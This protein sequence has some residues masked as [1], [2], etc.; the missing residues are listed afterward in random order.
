MRTLNVILLI[1][2][3][4]FFS[5]LFFINDNTLKIVF[6]I[7]SASLPTIVAII[8]IFRSRNSDI[9]IK[10]ELEKR[11]K[12]VSLTK[13]EYDELMEKNKIDKNTIYYVS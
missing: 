4:I 6:T 12:S 5:L 11:M 2:G 1:L 10:K 3:I 7:L 13:K 9:Q 8:E